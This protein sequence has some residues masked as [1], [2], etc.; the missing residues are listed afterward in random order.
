MVCSAL[1]GH[2]GSICSIRD[3][4]VVV[5]S[6]ASALQTHSVPLKIGQAD[7]PYPGAARRLSV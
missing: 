4:R 5:T 2:C 3:S 1:A 7:E 6:T